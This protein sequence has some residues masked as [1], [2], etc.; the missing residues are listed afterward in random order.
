MRTS[1]RLPGS[2]GRRVF[3]ILPGIAAQQWLAFPALGTQPLLTTLKAENRTIG[4]SAF[5]MDPVE[6]DQLSAERETTMNLSLT[7][8]ES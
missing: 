4:K 5:A 6:H 7:L 8:E 1:R 3:E 2:V